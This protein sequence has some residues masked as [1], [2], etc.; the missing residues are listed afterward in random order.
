MIS[1]LEKTLETLKDF[2]KATVNAVVD[3]F[4]DPHH[5]NR[6]L[7]ADEVGLGKT[8]VAKGVI[9]ELLKE[10]YLDNRVEDKLLKVTYICSNLT[11]AEENK[12]KLAVFKGDDHVRYVAEPTFS[13]LVELAAI[14]KR[15]KR[16][17]STLLEVNSLTPS[18]SFN[19]TSGHGNQ[20]ERFVIYRTLLEFEFFKQYREVLSDFF[21]DGVK[22]WDWHEDNFDEY[23]EIDKSISKDYFVEINKDLPL[24]ILNEFG[25]EKGSLFTLIQDYLQKS[26]DIENP[27]RLRTLFRSSL[28]Q[29]CAKN[30]N[31]DLF[32]LD[33]FQRFQ[34]L[35]NIE[36]NSEEA[37]I[38]KEVFKKSEGT[39]I[40]LLSATPFKALSRLD[41]DE[42][43]EAH[44]DELRKLLQFLSS[45]N[46]D[47][48]ETYEKE[49]EKLL[50]QILSL[51]DTNIDVNDI[52]SEHKYSVEKLLYS[53]ICRTERTQVSDGF[54]SVFESNHIV[55]HETFSFDEV[56]S[57]KAMDQLGQVLYRKYAG[58][59]SN[60]LL[61]FHKAAPWALSFLSGYQFKKHLDLHREDSEVEQA[62]R[63]STLGWLPRKGIKN[64]KLNLEKSAPNAKLR[65]MMEVFFDENGSELLW[66]PPSMPYYEFSGAFKEN[67][68]FTKS[69]LFSSWALV[70]RALSGLIS[71]EAERR[72]LPRQSKR[73]YFNLKHNPRFRF[74]GKSSIDIWGIVYPSKS[75]A[76]I[77][78]IPENKNVDEII[79]DRT[80]QISRYFNIIEND[81][82]LDVSN[83]Y[84]LAPFLLDIVNGYDE[85][86][87]SWFES[88][89]AQARE[90]G[91]K[92]KHL[93]K[94]KSHLEDNITLKE[95]PLFICEYLAELSIAGPGV[96]FLRMANTFWP[97][98]DIDYIALNNMSMATV[99]MF[100]KPESDSILTKLYSN[101]K[102]SWKM[103][104]NYCIDGNFQAMIDE[105]AHLLSTSGFTLKEATDRFNEVLGFRTASIACQFEE[106]KN[107]HL[108]RDGGERVDSTLRCHYAVP[109]GTQKV[110][111]DKATQRVSNV[112]DAFNS[113]FRPFVL[114][115]TSIGQEGLDFHWYCSRIIHWNLPSN[116]IDIE[117]RE[118]RI[119]RYKSLVVRRRVVEQY[120]QLLSNVDSD[121][122]S[123]L[124][125]I[126][127]NHTY[128]NRKSDLIPYWHLE[129]GSAKIERIV[130]MMPMS[131]EVNRLQEALKILSLYRLAFGQPRQEEL[132]SNLLEREMDDLEVQEITR[133]LVIRLAPLIHRNSKS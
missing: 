115:S 67:D 104:L 108:K 80:E 29:C 119:N 120:A 41:E 1:K 109:L 4:S 44:L 101:E 97:D 66:V 3:N 13:R 114:N 19:L 7:V 96:C 51:R 39:K 91:G 118:G 64:Y 130:P 5:S 60:Q 71:Y 77:S 25:T 78:F 124:F 87:F 110:G 107:K 131:K 47:F 62:L 90:E 6:V 106:D 117:Q 68:G 75:L 63:K 113:P 74:E 11:L 116:P 59:H 126:A 83:L 28:A 42:Q 38:A 84:A 20:W 103:L 122:W 35:L 123:K 21:R 40:L 37:L 79:A 132:L 33:E 98:T 31:A 133:K 127:D 93:L 27:V 43:N 81:I 121:F 23:Y 54:D 125:V 26:I 100:N 52:S 49:R 111:D 55:C 92:Y 10:K 72:N 61:E 99:S 34:S 105:Y 56:K 22:Y 48:L 12:K 30:L 50:R 89:L 36:Q 45:N 95:L 57:F 112:R 2:Q 102:K 85:N 24:S 9:A 76:Q 73:N 53:Y 58:R 128:E 46:I 88:Q 8:I 16:K 14:D 82:D 32:I 94:L 86:V 17:E 65:T 18:T 129:E 15:R 69:L 70:P